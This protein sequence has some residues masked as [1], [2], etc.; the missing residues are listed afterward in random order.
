MSNS[1]SPAPSDGG[2]RLLRRLA[3]WLL[4]ILLLGGLSLWVSRHMLSTAT[5]APGATLPL[6]S[7]GQAQLLWPAASER[8][9]VYFFAPWCQIC[10]LSMPGL[11]LLDSDHGSL[12]IVAVALDY[13]SEQ[14]VRAFV[15]DVGFH[16]EVLLGTEQTRQDWQITGYP[17]YYVIARNG[18]IQHKDMGISTPPGLWL[19]TR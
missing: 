18:Q 4:V 15:E 11:N 8:T 2:D 17:A 16:G 14:D 5:Q 12:R 1:A 3:G 7:G 6:L 9:L 10:R 13:D 19:R